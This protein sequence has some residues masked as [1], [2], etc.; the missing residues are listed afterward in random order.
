MII[1]SDLRI[2]TGSQFTQFCFPKEEID[3][4]NST[5]HC[6]KRLQVNPPFDGIRPSSQ[7]IFLSCSVSHK[8]FWEKFSFCHYSVLAAVVTFEKTIAKNFQTV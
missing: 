7:K 5:L 8:V 6:R 3:C 1:K 4:E 2:E